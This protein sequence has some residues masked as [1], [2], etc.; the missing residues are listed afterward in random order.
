MRTFAGDIRNQFPFNE[1]V[2][3]LSLLRLMSARACQRVCMLNA[4][5]DITIAL[6]VV[7]VVVLNSLCKLSYDYA[8]VSLFASSDFAKSWL[9]IVVTRLLLLVASQRRDKRNFG[10]VF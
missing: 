4:C 5:D 2:A 8:Y 3:F 9:L 10:E 1:V 7:V 6:A